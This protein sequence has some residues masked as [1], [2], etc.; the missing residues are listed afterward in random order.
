MAE[1]AEKT[2]TAC[3]GHVS[4]VEGELLD[5]LR[6]QIPAWEVVDGGLL[7]RSFK[8]GGYDETLDF[9]NA[10][11]QLATQENH[12]PTISFTWGKATVELCTHAIHALSEND[13]I[14]AVKISTNC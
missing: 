2:C 13:F 8:F 11:A 3:K 4:K 10:V 12:H 5:D 1:L 6:R 7:R 9:V 14:L